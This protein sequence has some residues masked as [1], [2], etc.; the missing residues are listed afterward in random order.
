V[1]GDSGPAHHLGNALLLD[2]D[3]PEAMAPGTAH[4]PSLTGK[5]DTQA[6]LSPYSDVAALLVFN[7]QMHLMNLL[8]RIGWEARTAAA[9]HRDAAH[10][11]HDAARE[12]VDYLLFID[13]TPLP[14]PVKSTSGFASVFA[15]LGPRDSQGRS[16]RQLDLTTRLLRYRCSYMIYSE[17]FDNL[18]A[19]AKE[20]IYKRMWEVLSRREKD[21][22]YD[23]L[24]F[25]ER[26]AIVDILRETRPGLPNYFQRLNP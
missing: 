15:Q 11:L 20:A 2:P 10:L 3:H 5:F 4:L 26:R 7:H 24:A 19:E 18:P 22:R 9:E 23:R 16:L 8:T 12:A 25:A 21:P 1:T 14:G 13:E 17:A 6:Y